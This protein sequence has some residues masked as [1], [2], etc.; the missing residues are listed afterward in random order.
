MRL[1]YIESFLLQIVIYSIIWLFN[2]YV[3]SLL[4]IILPP[5]ALALLIIAF[6]V[7]KVE[8]SKVPKSYF[9]HM[10]IFVLA[11]LLVGACFTW[12]YGGDL[13]WLKG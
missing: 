8:K 11:P 1:S 2:E 7:E 10:L 12:I 9:V 3:G 13:E 4:S 5:I 6:L